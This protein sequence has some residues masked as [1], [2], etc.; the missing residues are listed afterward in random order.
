[1]D[2]LGIQVKVPDTIKLGSTTKRHIEGILAAM[3]TGI[4]STDVLGMNN[5]IHIVFKCSYGFKVR[6]YRDMIIH[7]VAGGFMLPTIN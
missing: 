2:I 6:K 7:L 4:N 3:L 5:K 1:M